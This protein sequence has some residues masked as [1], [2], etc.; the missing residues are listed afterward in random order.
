MAGWNKACDEIETAN[1]AWEAKQERASQLARQAMQIIFDSL[2]KSVQQF[3]K[4]LHDHDQWPTTERR[5]TK[6]TKGFLFTKQETQLVTNRETLC[7]GDVWTN[8][9]FSILATS[10]GSRAYVQLNID[11]TGL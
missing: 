3:V 4:T 7:F 10:D 9:R 8:M 2:D 11:A 5:V 6:K 1:A